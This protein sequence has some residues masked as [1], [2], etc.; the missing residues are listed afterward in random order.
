MPLTEADD[1]LKQAEDFCE[2]LTRFVGKRIHTFGN[3][4]VMATALLMTAASLLVDAA[5][6]ADIRALSAQAGRVLQ[7][8]I[9]RYA[10]RSIGTEGHPALAIE[11]RITLN[12]LSRAAALCHCRSMNACLTPPPSGERSC[13]RP[14][15]PNLGKPRSQR[16]AG[17]KRTL[18]LCDECFVRLRADQLNDLFV[19]FAAN[20]E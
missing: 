5:A 12:Q 11:H 16:R 18:H 7:V 13:R 2:E 8:H 6:E 1:T 19:R 14:G 4:D 3:A 17:V 9:D 10:K 15:C 20:Q